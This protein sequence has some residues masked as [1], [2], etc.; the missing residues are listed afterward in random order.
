VGANGAQVTQP[1]EAGAYAV[2]LQPLMR[3]V[4][5]VD[6]QK[7]AASAFGNEDVHHA[8]DYAP[9][10]TRSLALAIRSDETTKDQAVHALASVA[11][12]GAVE[13]VSSAVRPMIE[14][15]H[16]FLV[17]Q[18]SRSVRSSQSEGVRHDDA[19]Q[20]EIENVGCGVAI[21]HAED[22]PEETA[23]VTPKVL[24]QEQGLA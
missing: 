5:P 19:P 1:L 23:V 13:G 21:D 17:G 7:H 18:G 6:R 24:M 9:F 8:L 3:S 16:E 12:P 11:G 22:A 20:A 14:M 2:D 15:A 10:S 4:Y